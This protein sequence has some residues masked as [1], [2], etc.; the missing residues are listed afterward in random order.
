L[1]LA[2]VADLAARSAATTGAG[3][4][5][6]IESLHVRRLIIVDH[7]PARLR[8]V[9]SAAAHSTSQQQY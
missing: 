5:V 8:T 9:P 7:L 3:T 1:A 4:V 2:V 6:T